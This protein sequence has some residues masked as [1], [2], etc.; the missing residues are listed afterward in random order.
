[1]CVCG[2]GGGGERKDQIW[3][4]SAVKIHMI[5]IWIYISHCMTS[6]LKFEITV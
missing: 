5:L 1:M 3:H 6:L 4:N 2:G